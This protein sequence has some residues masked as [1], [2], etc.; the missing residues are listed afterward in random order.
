MIRIAQAASSEYGTEWGVPPNQRRTG[1]TKEK[2]WG[3]L[4]GELNIIPFATNNWTAVFRPINEKIADKIAWIMQRAVMNGSFL[5]YGQNNGQYPR[6]GVF[7]ALMEM[8][9][10]DPLEIKVLCNC[11]CSSLSGAAIYF[12]GVYE[13]RL[14]NMNTSTERSLLLGTGQ[15]LE[16]RDQVLLQSGKGL[17][18]GDVLWKQGHTAVVL[19]TDDSL[20]TTP[21]RTANCV[22]CNLRTGPGTENKI[23]K[24]LPCGKR[25]DLISTASNG[26][27]QVKVDGLIGYI[28]PKYY[29]PLP[30][31]KATADLW[32]RKDAGTS[33]EKIIVIPKGATVYLNGE[34]KRVGLTYWYGS[35]YAGHEGFA[36]G[37]YLEVKK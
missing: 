1:V 31:T 24:A 37:K 34:K 15:F 20:I 4:D 18:R 13:P 29:E 10:P 11:D 2:P 21:C 28:S 36:S 12:A 9:D 32:L 5:G 17:R 6:T 22:S 35:I 27:G 16:L 30:T 23:I 19:D 8:S 3:N 7:D 26:W 33:A 14:R 25:V